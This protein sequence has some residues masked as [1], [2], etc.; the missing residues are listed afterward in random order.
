MTSVDLSCELVLKARKFRIGAEVLLLEAV[1]SPMESNL[2]ETGHFFYG[3]WCSQ[4]NTLSEEGCAQS[5]PREMGG[6]CPLI[7]RRESH[8]L[9][10]PFVVGQRLDKK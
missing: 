4:R 1:E 5:W 8:S 10:I 3:K 6:K 2:S 7:P 9:S